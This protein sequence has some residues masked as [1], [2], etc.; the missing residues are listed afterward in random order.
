DK[1]VR[2]AEKESHQI[3]LEPEGYNTH[4]VYLNGLSMSLPE[5]VQ[6]DI[7]RSIPGLER[8]EIMR[9]A[10]AVEYDYV[11][12]TQIHPSLETKPISGLFF[13]GQINGTTGYEEAAAQGLMAGANA[14]L[15][16][17]GEDPII[18]DRSQAYVGVL[19]DD[20]VTKGTEEPYRMFTS[21][22]E[23][24]LLLRQDNADLRL[25]ELGRKIGLVSDDAYKVFLK[26][27]S[28]IETE[29]ERLRSIKITPNEKIQQVLR[30]VESSPL[31]KP[32]VLADLLRRPELTYDIVNHISPAEEPLPEHVQ[33]SIEIEL[34][35]EGYIKR[36][37]SQVYRFQDLERHFIPDDFDYMS[38]TSMR[39]EAREKFN[40]IQ[41]RSLG[42]ASRI[43]GIS[44]ADIS[45]LMI[46]LKKAKG[47]A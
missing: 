1:V 24:R 31:A 41:P 21:L 14:A 4:E 35:Y 18:L 47:A 17:R 45:V 39:N 33:E 20:L 36:Q 3:F 37:E 15:K 26:R 42:Q 29:I 22:A 10:Y 23:Y 11:P 8:A 38:V 12:P 19:I 43:P 28:Q 30:Q 7:V 13:A 44:P 6:V 2:F 40:R 34:K 27:K 46:M 32:G 25:T 5:D 9:P 16:A